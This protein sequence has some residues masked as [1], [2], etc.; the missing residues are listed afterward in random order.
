MT[1][2]P[3]LRAYLAGILIPTLVLPLMLSVCIVGRYVYNIPLPIERVI[4]FPMA[5]VPNLWGVWNLLYA[6]AFARRIS[7][8]AF[9]SILPLILM[10]LGYVVT[11]LVD[12]PIP[13]IV[14]AHLPIMVPVAI[15]VY[16]F[17]WKHAVGFL[18]SELSTT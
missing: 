6:A 13:H 17:L 4:V 10:P 15:V 2:H 8:G 18:N 1:R 5:A 7:I 11:R 9:G 16:Y 14:W 3:Y 12:F